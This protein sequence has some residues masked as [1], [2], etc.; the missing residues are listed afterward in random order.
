MNG[1]ATGA[2]LGVGV[3][4]LW[5]SCW[6]RPA[7][8][9]RP[10]RRWIRPLL[11][12]AGLGD[13]PTAVLPV[14]CVLAAVV[15][16]VVVTAVTGVVVLG[17]GA[18]VAAATAP[19]SLLRHRVARRQAE[20]AAQW[21][22]AVDALAAAVRAGASLPEAVCGLATRGPQQLRPAF[23]RFAAGHRASGAFDAE[24]QHLRA[25]LA[26]PVFDRL[27]ATLRMT[28]QVGG[29]DLGATLRTLS[30]YLRED[31]RTRGELL[32]RQSWTVSAARLA[33]AAPWVVLGLLATRPGTLDAY[34]DATGAVVLAVGAVVSVGSYRVMV[35]LGRLPE[36]RRVLS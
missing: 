21:P 31:R 22:D 34:G 29:S 12:A 2:L 33:V 18:A 14:G 17:A 19:V 5:W 16:A 23:A 35:R 15:A 25:E 10:R 26:D 36:P 13:V 28:R 9:D 7:P 30:G 27:A 32:A 24:L 6:E 8:A 11:D 4:C 1:I 3:F 20:S